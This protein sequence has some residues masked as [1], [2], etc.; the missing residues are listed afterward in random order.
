MFVCVYAYQY[1]YTSILVSLII[2]TETATGV[3]LLKKL[4]DISQNWQENTFARDSFL[5]ILQNTSGQL[6]LF[7]VRLSFKAS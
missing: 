4:L 2:F 3:V 1:T 7:L 6:F 5:F